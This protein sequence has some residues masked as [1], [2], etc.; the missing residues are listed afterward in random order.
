MAFEEMV[1]V[2]IQHVAERSLIQMKGKY[3]QVKNVKSSAAVIAVQVA[4]DGTGNARVCHGLSV[5]EE[6]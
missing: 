1:K 3:A 6:K 5:M 2:W 4:K